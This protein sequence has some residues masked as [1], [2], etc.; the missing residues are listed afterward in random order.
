MRDFWINRELGLTGDFFRKMESLIEMGFPVNA[1]KRAWYYSDGNVEA[2]MNWLCSHM[3]DPD[4]NTGDFSVI[5]GFPNTKLAFEPP[6]TQSSVPTKPTAEQLAALSEEYKV[7]TQ[8]IIDQIKFPASSAKIYKEECIWCC[9]TVYSPAG[10][11]ISLESF[12]AYGERIKNQAPLQGGV[13]IKIKLSK[14]RLYG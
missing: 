4:Y 10:L 7:F 6:T 3:D 9:D 11:F 2:A 12:N 8:S 13:L 1:A 14:N 5:H